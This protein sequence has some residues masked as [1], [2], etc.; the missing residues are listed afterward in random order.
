VIS[1]K[2][3]GKNGDGIK[4]IFKKYKDRVFE[5]EFKDE[6]DTRIERLTFDLNPLKDGLKRTLDYRYLVGYGDEKV[7]LMRLDPN[8]TKEETP[9]TI[10]LKINTNYYTKI[11]H[12]R[13]KS[14][15]DETYRCYVACQ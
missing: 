7:L 10:Q 5:Y 9:L 2:T 4:E 1:C 15:E 13:F 11:Y 12:L 8:H 14:N 3:N 6:L